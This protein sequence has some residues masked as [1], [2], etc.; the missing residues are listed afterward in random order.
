MEFI[1]NLVSA[2][3]GFTVSGLS[4][5]LAHVSHVVGSIGHFYHQIVLPFRPAD[6]R[7]DILK[8]MEIHVQWA[9]VARGK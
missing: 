9:K 4:T 5:L 1:N 8:A 3:Q 7:A 6:V 2:L